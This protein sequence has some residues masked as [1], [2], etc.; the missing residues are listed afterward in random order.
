MIK[1]A[2]HLLLFRHVGAVVRRAAAEGGERVLLHPLDER[3]GERPA[4]GHT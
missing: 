3:G 1:T 2:A 4:G